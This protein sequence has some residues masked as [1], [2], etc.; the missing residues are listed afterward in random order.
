MTNFTSLFRF[1]TPKDVILI[2][3]GS[4]CA[5]AVG[6]AIPMFVVLWGNIT[7]NYGETDLE[8]AAK[9]TMFN[10]FYIG[11]GA[12]LAGWGMVGCW[13]IAGQRQSIACR[14]E[15]LK[16]LLRQEIGWF[17]TINQS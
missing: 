2:I 15:Y 8:A 9:N 13:M 3:V 7:N 1:A 5:A 11:A 17:D 10:F 4:L 16:S 6:V 14:R 12:L